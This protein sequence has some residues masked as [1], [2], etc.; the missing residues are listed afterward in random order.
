VGP[1]PQ[2]ACDPERHTR[3]G[4]SKAEGFEHH[5]CEEGRGYALFG[6]GAQRASIEETTLLRQRF[7]D[8]LFALRGVQSVGIGSCCLLPVTEVGACIRVG[9][10]RCGASIADITSELVAH[11]VELGMTGRRWG[12][13]IDVIGHTKPRCS[14]DDPECG[15]LPYAI[16]TDRRTHRPS[17]ARYPLYPPEHSPC[18]HDG[19]CNLGG[20]GNSCESWVNPSYEGTCEGLSTLEGALCGCVANHCAWFRQ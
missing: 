1:A 17:R 14:A 10:D 2:L 3:E 20:C 18:A 11:A 5:A 4:L 9:V 16:S 8:E 15:P 7:G 6:P 12:I 13:G 19:D